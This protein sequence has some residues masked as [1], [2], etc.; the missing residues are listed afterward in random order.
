MQVG[1]VGGVTQ[2]HPVVKIVH[3][4]LGYPNATRLGEI[5][6]TMMAP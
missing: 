6:A 5:A 3:K 4:M 1:V 2:T